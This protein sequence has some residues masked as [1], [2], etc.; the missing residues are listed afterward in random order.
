MD[1]TIT[2]VVTGS[3]IT[4]DNKNFILNNF[5]ADNTS[6]N[7]ATSKTV[8][9]IGEYVT[10]SSVSSRKPTL[11]GYIMSESEYD[12]NNKKTQLLNLINPLQDIKLIANNSYV[13]ECKPLNTVQWGS[14][15]EENN[16]QFVKFMIPFV[17]P[18]TIWKD[19]N[20]TTV[21]FNPIKNNF[22]FPISIVGDMYFGLASQEHTVSI[23]NPTNLDLG[24]Y[25]KLVA[26]EEVVNPILTNT[27]TNESLSLNISLQADDTLEI[28]T[29]FGNKAI[30][31]NNQDAISAFGFSNNSKWLQI[32]PGFNEF[33]YSCENGAIGGLKIT[34]EFT[35]AYWGVIN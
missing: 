12:L 2:N 25:F 23:F 4:F 13:L 33:T 9:Q 17:A 3:S 20:T 34:I 29:E 21:S 1:L 19:I 27:T 18:N 14:K 15:W 10:A 31:L 35:Q 11:I 7:H 30:L 28:N 16:N 26:I 5:N 6:V 24:C 22:I 32:A 8:K